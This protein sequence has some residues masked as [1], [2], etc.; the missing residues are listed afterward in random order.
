MNK[1]IKISEAKIKD[2]PGILNIQE[3][4]WVE[5]YENKKLGI[6]KKDIVESM[7]PK[8]EDIKKIWKRVIRTRRDSEGKSKTW[9]VKDKNKI[10]GF[11]YAVKKPAR[12][13]I[14]SIY[15]LPKYQGKGIGKSLM[16]S[17]IDWLGGKKPITLEVANYAKKTI[18]FYKKLG[19]EKTGKISYQKLNSG[20]KIIECEMELSF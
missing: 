9:I 7:R 6:Y 1:K 14:R 18:K 2:I 4:V 3:I 15:M 13:E 11:S 16:I 12:G 5:L 20:K 19:F 17:M 10:V 8:S